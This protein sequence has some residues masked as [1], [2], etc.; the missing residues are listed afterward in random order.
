M[1][2][3]PVM[4]SLLA[5]LQ[6]SRP[7]PKEQTAPRPQAADFDAFLARLATALRTEEAPGEIRSFIAEVLVHNRSRELDVDDVEATIG[8][9]KPSYVRTAIREGKKS[10]VR[11]YY[12]RPSLSWM[13]DGKRSWHL[14]GR[15][16]KR[17]RD[18]VYREFFLAKMLTRYLYPDRELAKLTRREGPLRTLWRYSRH[19]PPIDT[20]LVHGRS[21]QPL[22]Y[23]LSLTPD[24]K[25]QV[26][27]RLWLDARTLYPLRLVLRP[28]LDLRTKTLGP[29]EELRFSAHRSTGG[30][31][32]PTKVTMLLPD[33]KGKPRITLELRVKTMRLNATGLEP[34]DFKKP[35]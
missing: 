15:D 5:L 34:A 18:A 13:S 30:I 9:L 1:P 20:L 21:D 11:G 24:H 6:T 2:A 27:V 17:D 14:Q 35:D 10:F 29:A 19:K 22:D 26:D 25:G 3:V 23:P 28:V 33:K 16:Y 31:L 12:E 32:Q 7:S 8:F 4:L